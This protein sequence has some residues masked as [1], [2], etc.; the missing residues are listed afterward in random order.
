MNN[1]NIFLFPTNLSEN[2]E[3]SLTNLLEEATILVKDLLQQFANENDYTDKIKLAFGENTDGSE[4]KASWQAG[5]FTFP[6][7]QV[8]SASEINAANGAYARET[9]EIYLAQEFLLA[10]QQDIDV[11]AA[12]LLEEYGHYVDSE[13]NSVDS[14]GDE[15][16]IFSALVRGEEL[17]NSDLEQLRNEDDTTVVIIDGQSFEIEANLPQL[18]IVSSNSNP[19]DLTGTGIASINFNQFGNTSRINVSGQSEEFFP[20]V[21]SF[22]GDVDIAAEYYD[23][24]RELSPYGS[25][26][27]EWPT[28]LAEYKLS[29]SIQYKLG[30]NNNDYLIKLDAQIYTEIYDFPGYWKSLDYDNEFYNIG[31][32]HVPNELKVSANLN[33]DNEVI[34]I[35]NINSTSADVRDPGDTLVTQYSWNIHAA[36]PTPNGKYISFSE[37]FQTSFVLE[38]DQNF[39]IDIDA[40]GKSIHNVGGVSGKIDDDIEFNLNVNLEVLPLP[41]LVNTTGDKKALNARESPDSSKDDGLQITLRSLI[42]YANANDD[43]NEI[44]FAIPDDEQKYEYDPITETWRIDI[45]NGALEI[46]SPVTIDGEGVIELRGNQG[47]AGL[48]IEA[49]NSTIQGLTINN[50]GGHGIWIK[51]K[52]FNTIQNNNIGTDVTGEDTTYGNRGSGIY[53]KSSNTN[54]VTKNRISGNGGVGLGDGIN[55]E[56]SFY[57]Q[58]IKNNIGTNID[59]TKALGNL[60]NGINITQGGNNTIKDNVISANSDDGIDIR[61]SSDNI[62]HKNNIGTDLNGVIDLGNGERGIHIAGNNNE[63]GGIDQEKHQN[64]IAYNQ[65]L[66]KAGGVV[67]TTGTGNAILGNTIYEN[68][69]LGIDLAGDGVT[70]DDSNDRDTGANNLQNSPS[71]LLTRKEESSDSTKYKVSLNSTPNQEFLLQFFEEKG[72]ALIGDKTVTTN[73]DGYAYYD[74]FAGSEVNNLYATATNLAT[75]DTSEF[76]SLQTLEWKNSLNQVNGVVDKSDEDRV[77]IVKEGDLFNVDL[78]RDGKLL[79]NEILADLDMRSLSDYAEISQLISTGL[80]RTLG[81]GNIASAIDIAVVK[82]ISDL[83]KKGIFAEKTI[84]TKIL[85]GFGKVISILD[86]ILTPL[87]IIQGAVVQAFN[88]TEDEVGFIS[89]SGPIEPVV[90]PPGSNSLDAFPQIKINDD[91]DFEGYEAFII[92]IEKDD[93]KLQTI[94]EPVPGEQISKSLIEDTAL[95][96]IEDDDQTDIVNIN[97]TD[98]ENI[99]ENALFGIAGVIAG[100]IITVATGGAAAPATVVLVNALTAGATAALVASIG[101]VFKDN[102]QKE[103]VRLALASYGEDPDKIGVTDV[104]TIGSINYKDIQ[105]ILNLRNITKSTDTPEILAST[106]LTDIFEGTLAQFNGDIIPDFNSEDLIEILGVSLTNDNLNVT[107]GSAILDIDED[108]DGEVDS[109]ITLEGDFTNAEFIIEPLSIEDFN[110]TFITVDFPEIFVDDVSITEGNNGN[111]TITFTVSLSRAGEETITV[112][113]A[114]GDDSAVAGEDYIA[115]SGTLEFAPGETEKTITVEVISDI[116]FESNET[117]NINLSNPSGSAIATSVGTGT[118]QNDDTPPALKVTDIQVDSNSIAIEFNRDINLD[119]LN[120]YRG[121]NNQDA[122]SDLTLVG[123]ETGTV[124]GSLVWDE[125]TKTLTFIATTGIL[126]PDNY[127]LTIPS[128]ENGIVTPDGGVLDGDGDGI[129]GDDYVYEFT[130]EESRDR[131]LSIPNVTLA[132]GATTDIPITLNNLEGVTKLEF[133]FYYDTDLLDI[134]AIN[135]NDNLPASWQFTESEIDSANGIINVTIEG[136]DVLSGNNLNIVNLEAVV[137][138]TASYGETQILDLENVV[139]NDSNIS[140]IDDDGIHQVIKAGDTTGD[141]TLSGFDAYQMMRVSVGLDDGFDRFS[142]IDPM[143]SADMNRDGVISAFDAYHAVN[144]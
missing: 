136:T 121:E 4:L 141:G 28:A 86:R 109:T 108:L 125:F 57:N 97:P 127:T 26:E 27:D 49:G 50:F 114:T 115:T 34:E 66:N 32:I 19:I 36:P 92:Q 90:F 134:T 11:V 85:A 68:A 91:S 112:D 43:F 111:Q 138:D 14:P 3:L 2:T 54:T 22:H 140:A 116:D 128:R 102:L 73:D 100:A 38:S 74:F 20:N 78:N 95:V 80:T 12:V 37:N 13:I 123:E 105:D 21:I 76:S 9:N 44:K 118:I 41:Y 75:F 24:S 106:N 88:V 117:F 31:E 65:G 129:E 94:N 39:S 1:Q 122:L 25:A 87:D 82:T 64:I 133:D 23:Q 139:L 70:N 67:I 8:V 79:S 55:I 45:T 33:L 81:A 131:I 93:D 124:N 40:F 126:E 98:I 132:P 5:T 137:P 101:E 96:V 51:D 71:L 144:S 10:H 46:T 47:G 135:S 30:S 61:N 48:V 53:I 58:I 52:G 69:G 104:D 16:A 99:L 107:F 72:K 120:L 29:D 35:F 103:I 60:G 62:I 83:Q 6:S 7:I 84:A 63:I 119:L 143:I 142:T 42:E 110:S 56:N 130:I 18:E 89:N 59:S 15:G 77:F 113:Y 17:S